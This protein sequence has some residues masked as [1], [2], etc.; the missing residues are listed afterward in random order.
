MCLVAFFTFT[1]QNCSKRDA[2]VESGSSN[3]PGKVG[4]PQGKIIVTAKI[5]TPAS[6]GTASASVNIAL[7]K[8]SLVSGKFLRDD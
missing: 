4:L 2:I 3:N 5:S 6:P 8:D 1:A 7:T